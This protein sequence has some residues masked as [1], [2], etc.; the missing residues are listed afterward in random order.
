M[1]PVTVD[2]GLRGDHVRL[3]AG[4]ALWLFAGTW[5]VLF[6]GTALVVYLAVLRDLIGGRTLPLT[7]FSVSS[8]AWASS[9]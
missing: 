4:Q 7:A 5:P 6:F 3:T 2:E 8:S 1:C 9:V